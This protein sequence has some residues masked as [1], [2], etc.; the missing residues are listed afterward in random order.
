MVG[1]LVHFAAFF[2]FAELEF[3]RSIM[4]VSRDSELVFVFEKGQILST[5]NG[6]NWLF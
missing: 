6:M 5:V 4:H 3:V 2:F 1:G